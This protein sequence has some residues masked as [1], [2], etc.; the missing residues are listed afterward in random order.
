[1]FSLLLFAVDR[2]ASS[3]WPYHFA[4]AGVGVLLAIGLPIVMSLSFS[5]SLIDTL[6]NTVL[7]ATPSIGVLIYL[8][9]KH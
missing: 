5:C 8:V 1:M 3:S 2:T 9:V 4:W 6:V 7:V